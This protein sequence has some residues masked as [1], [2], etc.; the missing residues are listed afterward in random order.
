M[1]QHTDHQYQGQDV[2]HQSLT[3][4]SES[5]QERA[6]AKLNLGLKILSRR[7]DGFHDLLSVFQTVSLCDTV[8]VTPAADIALDCSD[9][10]LP[11]GVDNLAWHA[12]DLYRRQV[13]GAPEVSVIS[14]EVTR[15]SRF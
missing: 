1:G 9:P 11:S 4:N 13:G 2:S 14:V 8:R 5:C 12:A 10:N 6:C 7:Q 15:Y 3:D